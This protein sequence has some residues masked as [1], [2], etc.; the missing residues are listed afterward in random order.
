MD[1]VLGQSFRDFECLV[2]DDGSEDESSKIVGTYRDSRIRLISCPH[3]GLGAILEH[4]LHACTAPFIARMDADDLCSPNGF[5]RQMEYFTLNREIGAVGTQFA[6]IGN[7]GFSV[8][9]PTLPLHHAEIRQELLQ[10]NHALCHATMI[11]RTD[12][13]SGPEGTNTR[14]R[15]ARIGICSFALPSITTVANLPDVL[16]YYRVHS[17]NGNYETFMR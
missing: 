1:S 14:Y 11:L 13:L 8:P 5:A 2:L 16:Y 3:V 6:Y 9:S 10:G 12:L 17:G 15:W 7:L 4:G